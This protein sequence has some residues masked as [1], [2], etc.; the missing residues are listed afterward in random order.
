MNMP[1]VNVLVARSLI[2]SIAH[3]ATAVEHGAT[4]VSFDRDFVR[5][6]TLRWESPT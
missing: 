1:D 2:S 5:F 6:D 3:A 4:W